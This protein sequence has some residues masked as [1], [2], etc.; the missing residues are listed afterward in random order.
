M[1][2]FLGF[3]TGNWDFC[4]AFRL[5]YCLQIWETTGKLQAAV[6]SLYDHKPR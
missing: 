1:G 4:G 3:G 5:G 6:I 2:L